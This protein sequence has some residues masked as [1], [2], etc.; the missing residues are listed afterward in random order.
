MIV[1]LK[2]N[3]L[4]G[5]L[6]GILALVLCFLTCTCASA[7]PEETGRETQN[8][9]ETVDQTTE[10]GGGEEAPQALAHGTVRMLCPGRLNDFEKE[11]INRFNE[12]REDKIEPVYTPCEGDVYDP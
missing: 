3:V 7:P 2:K 10:D 9:P 1:M 8:E 4:K 6:A 11:I 5:G 12:S